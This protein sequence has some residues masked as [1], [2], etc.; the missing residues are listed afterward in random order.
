DSFEPTGAADAG[1]HLD[2][3]L[4]VRCSGDAERALKATDLLLH[5]GGFGMVVMDLADTPPRTA[6]RISLTS[7]FR[8]RRAVEHTSTVLLAVEPQPNART[9][10]TLVVECA[11]KR[12]AWSTTFR[13]IEIQVG[14]ASW[15]V[16]HNN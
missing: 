16:P 12:S 14:Q 11:R 13:G 4:W 10:A 2:R 6:R 9:C 8:L 7:W 1:V 3:L 15:P 5:G